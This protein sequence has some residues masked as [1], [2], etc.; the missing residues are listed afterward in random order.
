MARASFELC[1]LHCQ[2]H[3]DSSLR[4]CG[5]TG[6]VCMGDALNM[7]NEAVFLFAE[8]RS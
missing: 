8:R 6:H 4:R 2:R 7:D 3:G 5:G 1:G